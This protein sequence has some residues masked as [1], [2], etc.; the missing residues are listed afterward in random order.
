LTLNLF[1][2]AGFD[3]LHGRNHGVW[4]LNKLFERNA[5][6]C[7]DGRFRVDRP[8]QYWLDGDLG[9]PHWRLHRL[10]AVIALTDDRL[11]PLNARISK[12]M[13][14]MP[15]KGGDPRHVEIVCFRDSDLTQEFGQSKLSKQFH[16]A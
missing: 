1:S 5:E 14:F 16:A 6:S 8:L 11:R 15:G 7:V 3:A 2:P 10:R 12:A 13:Q 9:D 4:T